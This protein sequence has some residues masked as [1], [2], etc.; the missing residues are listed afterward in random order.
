M[1][2]LHKETS[3]SDD[4]RNEFV[5]LR[6]FLIAK[7]RNDLE[8]AISFSEILGPIKKY[9]ERYNLKG[10]D[11]AINEEHRYRIKALDWVVEKINQLTE[12]IR[13]NRDN[14][15]FIE[16]FDVKELI[17]HYNLVAEIVMMEKK[18]L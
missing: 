15:G 6:L 17:Y 13:E 2:I 14:T 12:P 9:M 8:T 3:L 5:S 18:I 10:Y 7:Q 11:H 4:Y 1:E 16:N